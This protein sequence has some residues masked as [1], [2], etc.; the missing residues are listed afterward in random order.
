MDRADASDVVILPVSLR[1]RV[2]N[3]LYADNASDRLPETSVAALCRSMAAAYE[4]IIL[5][6]RRQR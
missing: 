6:G 1:G 4:H 5:A 2:V 3:L